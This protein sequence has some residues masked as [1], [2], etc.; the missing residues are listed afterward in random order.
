M[1]KFSM[2]NFAGVIQ[3]NLAVVC[4]AAVVLVILKKFDLFIG[5]FL[6]I[7]VGLANFF[8]MQYLVKS[9]F[10]YSATV[11]DGKIP[12]KQILL[13]V[14]Q[15]FLKLMLL[16]GLLFVFV[17]FLNVNWLGLLI[18]LSITMV[19]YTIESIRARQCQ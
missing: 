3:K 6:G 17:K 8:V 19:I 15:S 2:K 5:I 1:R 13:Y 11:T 16:A 18:G 12:V 4:L 9:T 14:L 7:A 10:N